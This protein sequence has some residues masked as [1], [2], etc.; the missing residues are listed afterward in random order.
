MGPDITPSVNKAVLE[1]PG[2]SLTPTQAI[3]FLFVLTVG[4]PLLGATVSVAQANTL[5]I[6]VSLTCI[7]LWICHRTQVDLGD[8]KLKILG[9]FWLLKVG[10]TLF[11][12]YAGWIPQLDPS[13]A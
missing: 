2:F 4:V 10:I 8:K 6:F 7:G 12:L 11:L 5:I 3:L 13:S 9:S 1:R